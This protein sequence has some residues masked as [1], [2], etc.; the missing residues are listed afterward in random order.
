V[1]E[2]FAAGVLDKL[3]LGPAAQRA[4][5]PGII[6]VSMPAFGNGGPLSG[7]RAYG[8]TVEQASGLPFVN[9]EAHWP[10][11]NQHVAY[12]DPVAGLYAAGAVLAGLAR[13]DRQGGAYIDL[14]QVA[15]LFQL[16]AD[17][18]IAAQIGPKPLPR[19]GHRRQ[20]LALCAVVKTRDGW[21]TVAAD[22]VAQ[23][24]LAEVIGGS[25]EATL[26]AWAA[27]QDADAATAALQAAGVPTAPV[28]PSDGLT[29]DPQLRA[30][31]FWEEMERAFVGRHPMC[32]SPFRFDGKRP[33]LVRPA[34]TLGEHTADVLAELARTAG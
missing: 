22:N 30:S 33:A 6:S 5:R 34:P 7:I 2:N 16:G 12:G 32:A 14:S 24:A 8:S 23:A 31:G 20:R 1:V 21:L 17:A 25:D 29:R 27:G 13:R 15:C 10:P 28:R 9:G 11:S 3:G 19:T 18:I 26:A 4:L